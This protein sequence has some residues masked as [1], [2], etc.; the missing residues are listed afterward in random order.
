MARQNH[1]LVLVGAIFGTISQGIFHGWPVS[2][3]VGR[4]I[5]RAR[6]TAVVG[7]VLI[8]IP[9][10]IYRA[11]FQVLLPI[12]P[13]AGSP[14]ESGIAVSRSF[15]DQRLIRCLIV[16]LKVLPIVGSYR[17]LVVC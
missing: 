17:V 2:G 11:K 4:P 7:T 9:T 3:I 10:H 13:C 1:A 12:I 8:E 6:C 14:S 15:G 5:P 16:L